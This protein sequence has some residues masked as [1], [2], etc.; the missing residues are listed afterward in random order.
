MKNLTILAIASLS[1]LALFVGCNSTAGTSASPAEDYAPAS[2]ATCSDSSPSSDIT[3][4]ASGSSSTPNS[5][6]STPNSVSSSITIETPTETIETPNNDS[7][8]DYNSLAVEQGDFTAGG[9]ASTKADSKYQYNGI[10][11]WDDAGGILFDTTQTKDLYN[12][13]KSGYTSLRTVDERIQSRKG[14]TNNPRIAWFE[15]F[16]LGVDNA[17]FTKSTDGKVGNTVT[18]TYEK[19]NCNKELKDLLEK[20][21]L[22]DTDGD[23]IFD[24]ETKNWEKLLE[25]NKKVDVEEALCVKPTNTSITYNYRNYCGDVIFLGIRGPNV[26]TYS[27][28]NNTFDTEK[29][30]ALA[31]VDYTLT[32]KEDPD[33]FKLIKGEELNKY[34]SFETKFGVS[35]NESNMTSLM[36]DGDAPPAITSGKDYNRVGVTKT[37]TLGAGAQ[38]YAGM[39]PGIY[40][41]IITL[42]DGKEI[43]IVIENLPINYEKLLWG[44]RTQQEMDICVQFAQKSSYGLYGQYVGMASANYLSRGYNEENKIRP[45]DKN[46]DYASIIKDFNAANIKEWGTKSQPGAKIQLKNTKEAAEWWLHMTGIDTNKYIKGRTGGTYRAIDAL[47]SVDG[48]CETW[49]AFM[50][51]ILNVEGYTTRYVT[52]SSHAY[53]EVKVPAEITVSGKDQWIVIDNGV[54]IGDCTNIA[55]VTKGHNVHNEVKGWDC[56]WNEGIPR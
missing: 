49:S 25:Y 21:M 30:C 3:P 17:L 44:C 31:G 52:N 54:I 5:V 26:N 56:Y 51:C 10:K 27:A 42:K 32:C 53:I 41:C 43:P 50:S 7:N 37:G 6:S 36:T 8:S 18:V 22:K 29:D 20:P 23:G 16:E 2:S 9:Y 15:S 38:Y 11:G 47:N 4:N 48:D 33:A 39:K 55:R 12:F 45:T 46:I 14:G 35:L 19:I 24:E 13:V 34:Y 28:Y 40:N 1:S